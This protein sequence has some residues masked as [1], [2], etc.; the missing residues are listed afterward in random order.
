MGSG[1]EPRSFSRAANAFNTEPSLQ[2]S[3]SLHHM[4]PLYVSAQ[5]L[6]MKGKTKYAIITIQG[7]IC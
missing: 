7:G 1:T 4:W 3:E 5:M 2:P 6:R